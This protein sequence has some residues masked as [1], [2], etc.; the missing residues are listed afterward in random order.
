MYPQFSFSLFHVQASVSKL[1]G[2]LAK[3]L[4]WQSICYIPWFKSPNFSVNSESEICHTKY[5]TQSLL[6]QKEYNPLAPSKYFCFL[7]CE[8]VI[9][10]Q[11]F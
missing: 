4:L 11:A 1:G 2:T 5:L 9:E 7:Y 10:T 3:I 8:Y 6:T